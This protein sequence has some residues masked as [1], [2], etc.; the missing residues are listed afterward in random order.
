MAVNSRADLFFG[1]AES[2]ESISQR[3]YFTAAGN[4]AL[5]SRM[6]SVKSAHR[7]A[8]KVRHVI[9]TFLKL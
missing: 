4:I 1:V 5:S 3:F 9:F 7:R 2:A 6:G 8:G